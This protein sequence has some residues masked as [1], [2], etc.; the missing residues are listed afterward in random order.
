MTARHAT[1]E[2]A[3]VGSLAAK[4]TTGAMRM[5]RFD[6]LLWLI[7]GLLCGN[8]V[9]A[10]DAT[11][12][13]DGASVAGP[14]PSSAS[15]SAPYREVMLWPDDSF[16]LRQGITILSK[17]AWAITHPSMLVYT[18]TDAPSP[19]AAVLVFPGGGYKAVAIGEQ[20][21]LGWRGADV[22][23]WP[24]QAGMACIVVR[25]RVPNTGCSYDPKT[26]RHETPAIPMALQDAQRALSLVRHHASD[27]GIDPHRVGVM[28]FSAGGNLAVLSSTA[29]PHRTYA[30]IDAVDRSDLR[31]DFAIPV[32]PGHMTMEHKN[33]TPKALAAQELNTDI[34]VTAAIPPTLLIHAQDDPVDPVHY[35]EVYARELRRAGVDVSLILYANGGHAFGVKRQGTDSDRWTDDALAWLARKGFL[36]PSPPGPA[37]SR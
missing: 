23:R 7:P 1:C 12:R 14:A 21:T 35:S 32:Y 4:P 6:R 31:P 3:T 36:D 11:R 8:A 28:G 2:R 30:P 20:S 27:F 37:P 26:R 22:C 25:Y 34:V 15:G 9:A 5:A 24:T 17:E 19:T 18:P 16:V 29:F 10:Q 13:Q 33:K